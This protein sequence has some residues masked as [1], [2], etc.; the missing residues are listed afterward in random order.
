MRNSDSARILS[1]SVLPVLMG[2]V[3]LCTRY[4]DGRC[5]YEHS[6]LVGR[7]SSLHIR[8]VVWKEVC[9]KFLERLDKHEMAAMLFVS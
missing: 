9:R 2:L 6:D 4:R 1:V 5:I 7:G 8:N 3:R